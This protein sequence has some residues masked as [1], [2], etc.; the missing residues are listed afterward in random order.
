[1]FYK[2]DVYL[3]STCFGK[4][5]MKYYISF[6][7]LPNRK[8]YGIIFIKNRD[9]NLQKFINIDWS[10]VGFLSTNSSY[11][12]RTSQITDQFVGC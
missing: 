11:N 4:E 2:C 12:I 7:T 8:G 5:N 6:D 9:E 1:M 3:P 10:I